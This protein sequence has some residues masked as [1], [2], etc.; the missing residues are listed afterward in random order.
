M[1]WTQSLVISV[2]EGCVKN[3]HRASLILGLIGAGTA[4]GI[5]FYQHFANPSEQAAVTHR[6]V[7]TRV[8]AEY[9][10]A[11]YPGKAA[12]VMSNPFRQKKGQ[13]KQIYVFE[14]AGIRGLRKGFSKPAIFRVVFPELRA[15]CYQNPQSIYVDPKTTT[16][17]SYL[18][19]ENSFNVLAQQNPDCEII[20][21]LIGLP[22][23][24]KQTELWR[25]SGAPR[26]ALLLPDWRTL[27]D[28]EMVRAAFQSGK[29]IAAVL[30]KPGAPP[31]D[32]RSDADVRTEFE[33]RFLLVTVENIDQLRRAY[34]KLF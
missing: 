18:V 26:F 10:A 23:G 33:K 31:E 11:H 30:N 15:E 22:V 6:E 29:L 28:S 32:A 12:L 21:S 20:I 3:F 4:V 27:G 17:L 1:T 14:E 19:A 5:W 13:P 34:P 2:R 16:P 7:A 24:L 25:K 9:L 8:L